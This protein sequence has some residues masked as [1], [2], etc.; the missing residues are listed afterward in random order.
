MK[1]SAGNGA[2]PARTPR[3]VLIIVENLPVPFDRRVWQEA[4]ELAGHGYVVSV[5]CPIAPGCEK[6]N[7]V[8]D[9]VHIHRHWMPREGND[10]LGYLLEY[11]NALLWEFI[12]AWK[13]L[14]TTGFDVIH[15]SN[16]PDTIFLIGAFFKFFFGKKFIFDQ[17]D[18]MPE[19]YE[20]KF[21]RRGRLG[22]LIRL[23]ERLTFRTAD[24]SIA[25]NNSYR[26]IAIDRGRMPPEKVFVVRNGPLL[27]R[28]K[29]MPPVARLKM[30]RRF[31]VGYLGVIGRQEGIENLIEAVRYIVG[32]KGRHDIHF[33]IIGGG[34]ALEEMRQ[35]AAAVGVAA[36]ITF[37]GRLQD[38][39][40]LEI[41]NTADVC[42]NPDA[43]NEMNDKSTM[44][45]IM[46]Y[47]SLAK[48][49]VQFDVTEGRFSAAGA[50][51]YAIPNDPIDMG[52]K[53]LRLIDD[54]V[55]RAEMGRIGR[56]RI[57]TNLAWH[58]QARNLL[59]AYDELFGVPTV[60]AGADQPPAGLR[61]IA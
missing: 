54:P 30:G 53:I 48:P 38:P 33:T 34:P 1:A 24:V 4:T 7:E 20:A 15:A 41:L 6:R 35:L 12:L 42:V 36:H 2:A 47:M 59:A 14:L 37:T 31:M 21:G 10:G 17:H 26:Q 46:E 27:N 43:V 29:I 3:R 11:S 28:M 22:K 52:D 44:I 50:S 16:P 55:L 56:E 49:M 18:I 39:E 61:R 32:E 8:L 5:I 23:L 60:L 45:K 58:F 57:E 40:L 25:T 9:G 51:L 19:L 13:V